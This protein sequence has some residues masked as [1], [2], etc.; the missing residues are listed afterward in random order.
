M[1]ARSCVGVAIVVLLASARVAAGEPA[2]SPVRIKTVEPT[3]ICKHVEPPVCRD[4]PP[5][6]FLDEQSWQDVDADKRKTDDALTRALA[7]NTSLRAS[8][9]AWQP[10]WLTLTGALIAGAAAG[11]Y[12]TR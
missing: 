4:L 10:G 3:T 5:G 12:F 2:L 9:K 11:V 1:R 6:R 7:E 8:A